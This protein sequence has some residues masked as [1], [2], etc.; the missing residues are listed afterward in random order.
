MIIKRKLFTNAEGKHTKEVRKKTD[1]GDIL[2]AAIAAGTAGGILGSSAG[3]AGAYT[4]A[5]IGAGMGAGIGALK[6]AGRRRNTKEGKTPHKPEELV[7][8]T[9]PGP[10]G[11]G[12]MI[13]GSALAGAGLGQGSSREHAVKMINEILEGKSKRMKK[14]NPEDV[15][16]FKAYV[17]TNRA[18]L[19]PERGNAKIIHE[20]SNTEFAKKYIKKKQIKG[21]LIGG[22]VLGGTTAFGLIH[23]HNKKK[24]LQEAFEKDKEEFKKRKK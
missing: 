4:G 2:N 11:K 5:A 6:A 14:A 24:K 19:G 23:N 15:E 17:V 16:K 10:V 21:A 8:N 3:R 1:K 20:I 13:T 9:E 12:V 7:I 22:A 18:A